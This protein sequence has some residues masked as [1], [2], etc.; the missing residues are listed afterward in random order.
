MA[1]GYILSQCIRAAGHHSS[2]IT[3]YCLT[4]FRN[5]TAETQANVCMSWLREGVC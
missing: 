2:A 4:R 1:L 3:V 5:M